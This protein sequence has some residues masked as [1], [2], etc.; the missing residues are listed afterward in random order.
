MI[1]S[2]KPTRTT[3]LA[4]L[5]CVLFMAAI[6]CLELTA[7]AR[8]YYTGKRAINVTV[9]IHGSL[10][11]QL[12]P[13]DVKNILS[14]ILPGTSPY[15]EIIKRA[16]KNPLLWQDQALLQEGLVRV[17]DRVFDNFCQGC[18]VP[19]DEHKAAYLIA[20]SYHLFASYDEHTRYAYYLFGHLGLLSH[21]YRNQ[22]AQEELY[23]H[24]CDLLAKYNKEYWNVG[25]TIVAHSHGGNIALNLV[26]AERVH[27]RG[28]RIDNLVMW[29]TPIHVETIAYI[30]DPI[31]KRVINCH[32]D[33]DW[34]QGIDKVSTK[35][36]TCFKK[37]YDERLVPH[38]PKTFSTRVYDV[39]WM[40]NKKVDRI[41]HGNMWLLGR[42]EKALVSLDPLPIMVLTPVLL[43]LL[44]THADGASFDC[45]IVEST[46]DLC[47]EL[48]YHARKDCL[49]V[50]GNI[51][52]IACKARDLT[53]KHWKSADKSRMVLL[54]Y[55]TGA[56]LWQA[57]R[58][59]FN[60]G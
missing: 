58:E 33:G 6:L 9:F 23:H 22:V 35:N 46:Q 4:S 2:T 51:H 11:T 16:R 3:L 12:W 26:E 5:G 53:H 8:S 32:S 41:G 19:E 44:D 50:S 20:P 60:H 49:S 15:V 45:N 1:T 34:V 24:L 47:L 30:F 18:F 57:V 39:R 31:F 56:S 28:L 27:K 54:N 40:V 52:A 17:P 29:G 36:R 42:E 14:G 25:L 55:Q 48:S 21:Q 7:L 59:W 38:W 13:L 10:F 43:E 37:L